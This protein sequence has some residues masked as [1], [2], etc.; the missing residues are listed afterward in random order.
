LSKRR[1]R[2]VAI[3]Q[4][5]TGSRRF[6]AKVLQKIA[7]KT[8][9]AR[10][11]ERTA[12][13]PSVDSVVVATTRKPADRQLKKIASSHGAE[14]TMGSEHDVLDRFY[15]SA[16]KAGA[17]II[18]RTTSDCPLVD[19]E[20]IEACIQRF[21]R[22]SLDYVSNVHP[23]TFPDGLDVEVFSFKALERSWKK[24]NGAV[25]REHVTVHMREAAGFKRANIKN[26]IDLSAERWTVDTP[27]D[28]AFVRAVFSRI[29]SNGSP[30]PF[31]KV[32]A[33]LKSSP[34]LRRK[35]A[36]ARNE[37][38][39]KTIK[40]MQ[41]KNKPLK[42]SRGFAQ[43]KRAQKLIPGCSQTFS[44]AP[45][46]WST[47]AAP[48]FLARA[49][50]A[51][52]WDLDGNKYIDY[53][54]ALGPIILGHC[55]PRVNAAAMTQM[56]K[57]Q[58]LSLP[59]T[60]ETDVA[61]LICK[62]VPGA[63][64]VRFAKNGSDVTTGAVRVARAF[65]GREHIAQCGY[66]GWH[67]WYIGTTTRD[68][69]VPRGVKNLTHT[70]NFNDLESLKK[71]FRKYPKKIAAVILE[72]MGL[73]PPKNGFLKKAKALAHKHG[74]LIIF[75]EVVT[76]FRCAPGGAQE[77]FG[78]RADLACFGKALANGWPLSAVAGRRDVMRVFDEV[79]FSFTMGGEAVSLAAAFATLKELKKPGLLK[80]MD[81]LGWRLQDGYNAIAT[82]QGATWTQ[83]LG[84]GIRHVM[85]FAIGDEETNLAVKTLFQQECAK[86]GVLFNGANGICAAHTRKDIDRTL[87]VYREAMSITRFA[88]ENKNV[89]QL[90]EG[91]PLQ[92]VF[93]KP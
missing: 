50:G 58:A 1:P 48:Q 74:A 9:L 62:M 20:I 77:K 55:H 85:T 46:Q 27:Q 80:G 2:I 76:G 38:L 78:V 57:G 88:V 10:V 16:K 6:P 79:F 51:Y 35:D 17:D 23:P 19:P 66:H 11:I 72:P 87:K 47:G 90:L 92:P 52:A 33:L 93:R 5:R 12:A 45:S 26:T 89:N 36:P 43:L 32:L 13:T 61:E 25:Q 82:E 63:E 24:A 49:K 3:I 91:K 59:T 34:K 84:Y 39:L 69:G 8:M 30:F 31:K 22:G 75:D 42:L 64:M 71:L 15:H 21:L 60:L 70:F 40:D 68:G 37:G 4:A 65:T 54:L 86:R 7:G 81:K 67:D 56:A 14:F 29:S 83:A 18:V 41:K 73:V 53:S 28:I 44:K